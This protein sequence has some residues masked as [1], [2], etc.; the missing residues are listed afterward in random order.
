MGDC[1]HYTHDMRDMN[2]ELFRVSVG[3]EGTSCQMQRV[4]DSGAPTGG[5]VRDDPRGAV[6]TK[7]LG[8][9]RGLSNWNGV[10]EWPV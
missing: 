7:G 6:G 9:R 4:R 1:L 8:C 10:L 5:H 3:P 2:R